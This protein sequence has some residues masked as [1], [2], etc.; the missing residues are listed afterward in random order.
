MK[1]KVNIQMQF[2][3]SALALSLA[4]AAGCASP[5]TLAQTQAQ[6]PGH[7]SPPG[8]PTQH[9][10]STLAGEPWH[11]LRE[12]ARV[13]SGVQ[14]RFTPEQT[15]ELVGLPPLTYET[16]VNLG[17][18]IATLTWKDAWGGSW[19]AHHVFNRLVRKTTSRAA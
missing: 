5:Q 19:T 9:G 13:W 2:C 4:T 17:L 10:T 12:L 8:Y 16:S 15:I 1:S 7:T 14:M 6:P 11:P 3:D 18:T